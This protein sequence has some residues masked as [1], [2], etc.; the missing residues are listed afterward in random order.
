MFFSVAL[1]I[2]VAKYNYEETCA[3]YLSRYCTSDGGD[4][5]NCKINNNTIEDI[6]QFLVFIGAYIVLG[7][8]CFC[9]VL[10][11]VRYGI[12]FY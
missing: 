4:C 3:W 5:P 2:I 7:L 12:G 6:Y 9:I 11:F 10:H 8:G 1:T